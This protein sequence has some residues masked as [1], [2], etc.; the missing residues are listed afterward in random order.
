MALGTSNLY[1]VCIIECNILKDN[2]GFCTSPLSRHDVT[3]F[4]IQSIFYYPIP[5]Q[6]SKIGVSNSCEA[7]ML[8]TKG[9]FTNIC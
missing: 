7:T 3:Y 1:Y 5:N 8:T 9:T 4:S 6:R 2:T